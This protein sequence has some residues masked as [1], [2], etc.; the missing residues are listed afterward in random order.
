[1]QQPQ[2]NLQA[3]EDFLLNLVKTQQ[4]M[5]LQTLIQGTLNQFPEANETQIV[6]RIEHLCQDKQMQ[7]LDPQAKPEEQ[8]ICLV[9]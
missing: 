5:G 8:V 1:M 6:Q 3:V 2:V 4:V 9:P 7:L